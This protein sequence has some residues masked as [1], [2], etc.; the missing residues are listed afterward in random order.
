MCLFKLSI[1]L[2]PAIGILAVLI[3]AHAN[4]VAEH[5]RH[6]AGREMW[7]VDVAVLTDAHCL[8]RADAVGH[9][10]ANLARSKWSTTVIRGKKKE[11]N[12]KNKIRNCEQCSKKV[13]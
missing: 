1:L 8:R 6:R 9:G 10:H 5:V 13:Y 12:Q 11:V 2:T 7:L 3:V 4:V